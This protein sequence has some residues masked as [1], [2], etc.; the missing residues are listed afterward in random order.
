MNQ[1]AYASHHSPHRDGGRDIPRPQYDMPPPEYHAHDLLL[2]GGVFTEM[3][4]EYWLDRIEQRR[5][6]R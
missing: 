1:T 3:S 6:G 5:V 4:L 2:G